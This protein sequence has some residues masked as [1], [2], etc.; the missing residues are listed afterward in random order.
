MPRKVA[1]PP[2]SSS[3]T[4][5]RHS[6]WL[7]TINANRKTGTYPGGEEALRERLALCAKLFERS[8]LK[9]Y[10]YIMKKEDSYEK[11]V[12]KVQVESNVEKGN[13]RGFLHVH[14]YVS[15]SHTTSCR[16]SYPVIR[17]AC[18]KIL[19]VPK[20]HFD[21]KLVKGGETIEQVRAY[22]MKGGVGGKGG[23]KGVDDGGSDV[24]VAEA[25]V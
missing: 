14:I 19:G 22:V 9:P 8:R 6:R 24:V 2:S 12:G 5:V 23:G 13:K 10:L 11:N 16:L 17:A 18:A 20:P 3:T 15:V 7:I 1:A 21:A 25:E 4:K